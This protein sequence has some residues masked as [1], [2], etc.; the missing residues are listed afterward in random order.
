[1]NMVKHSGDF[2]LGI[3]NAECAIYDDFRPSDM[4]PS[5]FINFIDYNKHPMNV[6]G[7]SKQNNYKRIFI[8]S[9][10]NPE[11]LYMGIASD[12]PRKQWMRRMEIVKLEQ[13]K[14]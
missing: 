8:T 3:G 2:W 7:G 6:K 9:V 12:E 10:V 11:Y 5:E 14:E 13:K 4:K 1:M